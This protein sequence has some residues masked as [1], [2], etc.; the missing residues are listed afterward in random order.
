VTVIADHW[1]WRP[2]WRPGRRMYTWHITFG[3]LPAVA[4]LAAAAQARL[5]GLDGLDLVPVRWL[6][7]TTQGVGFTDEVSEADVTTITA[8]AKDRLASVQP[9]QVTIGPARVASEGIAF[10]VHPAEALAP[11]RDALRA[12]IADVWTTER[13]PEAAEWTPHVSVA[14]SRV[15]GP[16]DIY[17]AALD[18]ADAAAE[19]MIGAVQL[20]ALRRDTHLYEWATCAEVELTGRRGALPW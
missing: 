20:I 8:A 11:L 16:A 2:G 10:R 7:L 12:A 9:L 6:H 19:V 17:E 15:T 3:D 4:D 18:G 5:A 1:W 14:Y 13:V